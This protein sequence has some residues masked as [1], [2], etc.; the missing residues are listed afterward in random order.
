MNYNEALKYAMKLCSRQERCKSEVLEKLMKYKLSRRDADKV[1]SVLEY[2]DFINEQ[3]FAGVY[4]GDK[5]RFNKWGR[6]KIRYMLHQKKIPEEI[7]EHA[8]DDIE[9]DLYEEMIRKE[10]AGK[11]K[12]LQPG[13]KW[14]I[15]NR[16]FRFGQQRGYESGLIRK[17]L[18]SGLT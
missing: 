7:I 9:P 12:I 10:L 13:D 4:A 15:R 1:I 16:L 17:I 3:R 8:L 5:M 18:D 6:I 14:D 2:E 11:K